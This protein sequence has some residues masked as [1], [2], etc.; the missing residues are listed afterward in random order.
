MLLGRLP[1]RGAP[2]CGGCARALRARGALG[3]ARRNALRRR[4]LPPKPSSAVPVPP[5]ASPGESLEIP[6]TAFIDAFAQRADPRTLAEQFAWKLPTWS[7][8]L[9]LLGV[10]AAYAPKQRAVP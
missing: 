6:Y 7:G 9:V 5:R 4:S 3:D 8:L 2:V 10:G 1:H